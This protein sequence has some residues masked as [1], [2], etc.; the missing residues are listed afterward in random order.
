MSPSRD[1]FPLNRWKFW[2]FTFLFPTIRRE[3]PARVEFSELH[4]PKTFGIYKLIPPLFNRKS[5]QN[6]TRFVKPRTEL[7]LMTIRRSAAFSYRNI[8]GRLDRPFAG[9]ND[10]KNEGFCVSLPLKHKFWE[11]MAFIFICVSMHC[12]TLAVVKFYV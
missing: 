12:K 7:G 9:S 2:G 5:L 8:Y 4:N 6:G 3:L 10:K 11:W 1:H